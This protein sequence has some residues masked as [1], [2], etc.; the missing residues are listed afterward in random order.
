[1]FLRGIV[2]TLLLILIPI[3]WISSI[4]PS[5]ADGVQAPLNLSVNKSDWGTIPLN[6][7]ANQKSSLYVIVPLVQG[8]DDY[9]LFAY[10]SGGTVEVLTSTLT[11][12]QPAFLV[13]W[14]DTNGNQVSNVMSKKY[15]FE[16][17][18]AGIEYH[19]GIQ[20]IDP[21]GI[22]DSTITVPT[23]A[24]ASLAG[25]MSRIRPKL[26][27]LEREFANPGDVITINGSNLDWINQNQNGNEDGISLSTCIDYCGPDPTEDPVYIVMDI[28]LLDFISQ[29]PSKITFEF[30]STLPNG[31]LSGA[32]WEVMP[33]AWGAR[34]SLF[35][36]VGRTDG[37]IF[38]TISVTSGA[39][40]TITPGTLSDFSDGSNAVYTIT[41]DA[42]YEIA[43]ATVDGVSVLDSLGDVDGAIKSYTFDS[44][45]SNHTISATFRL[46][47][48]NPPTSLREE[49]H[50][51][52][53]YVGDGTVQ[54]TFFRMR[55]TKAPGV[56]DYKIKV[57]PTGQDPQ[58]YL[59]SEMQQIVEPNP[60][61]TRRNSCIGNICYATISALS[62]GPDY[63][64]E[65]A[66]V[67]GIGKSDSTYVSRLYDDDSWPSIFHTYFK[68]V[69]NS[70]S[71]SSPQPGELIS[72]TGTHLDTAHQVIF[73]AYTE[74]TLENP[75]CWVDEND[76]E[77]CG[78]FSIDSADF[79]SVS[80]TS[81]SF[82]IP[83][84]FPLELPTSTFWDG[85]ATR[86]DGPGAYGRL[87]FALTTDSNPPATHGQVPDIV[88]LSTA[89]A[90]ST[91]GANFTLGSSTGTTSVGATSENDGKIATQS[92]VGD[93]SYGSVISYTTYE[94][95]PPTVDTN[96]VITPPMVNLAMIDGYAT[97]AG[98]QT[99]LVEGYDFQAGATVTV[100]G[101]SCNVTARSSVFSVPNNRTEF[102]I[103]CTM[104]DITA[105]GALSLVVTNDDGGQDTWT[106]FATAD[107]S[108]AAQQAA[109]ALAAQQA[110][111]ALAAQQAADALAAQQ[112]A[113]ALAAQQAAALAAQ[114]A[115][116]AL[117]AQQ[118]ADALAAQRA[119]EAVA[120]QRA[121]EAVAA[122]RAA[123]AVAAQ[124]AAEA[125]AAQR[126]AELLAAQQVLDAKV[127]K[128]EREIAS[129][130][131]KYQIAMSGYLQVKKLATKASYEKWKASIAKAR[132]VF[133]ISKSKA[134]NTKEL[135]AAT[136]VQTKA[137]AL[138][139]N[140]YMAET[141]SIKSAY[142]EKIN[143]EEKKRSELIKNVEVAN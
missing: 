112:A 50:G 140:L 25:V 24:G 86:N 124:R 51:E 96:L 19:F 105:F 67:G 102:H 36:T 125:V 79:V 56:L 43:S 141:S 49:A 134:R 142:L 65:V 123:E 31:V 85:Y 37:Q 143:A 69:N 72:I 20:S 101:S 17:L 104:P 10:S 107:P 103:E 35:L 14:Y 6:G 48:E 108:I 106:V 28:P 46:P 58:I 44:V 92:L 115:A 22:A 120:A 8:V 42:G 5:Y 59:F 73:D 21:L 100:A 137:V 97:L 94:Y 76:D 114:Q 68:P 61:Y 16:S 15:I 70:I 82:Y 113:D 95:L 7:G 75:A 87:Q 57:T 84:S 110:A 83:S 63:R 27:S 33:N 99:L 11:L 41:P 29:S 126:A 122:Q 18:A 119:A 23:G 71:S 130:N 116:D 4:S 3:F 13:D 129:V 90:V 45:T 40:G 53:A 139:T 93:Q 88:N 127:L 121:A 131:Q 117:A 133:A 62:T 128:R 80:P 111:D 60:V 12:V 9:R 91:L 26:E 54:F 47:P 64:I 118:A 132:Q 109:A 32:I 2:V 89:E 74:E 136:K 38:R 135:I 34:G 138:A 78:G 77:Y 66:S 55:W 39:N 30:P 98:G 81:I 1:M 52:Y